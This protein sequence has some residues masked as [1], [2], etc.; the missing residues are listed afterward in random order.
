MRR[1]GVILGLALLGCAGFALAQGNLPPPVK[2]RAYAPNR[3]SQPA[4]RDNPARFSPETASVPD[5]GQWFPPT[6]PAAAPAPSKSQPDPIAK[7]AASAEPVVMNV[8]I[9]EHQDR[10]RFVI[11][12]SDPVKLR[13]LTLTNPNRVVIDMPEV[14][15]RI[16]GP[17]KP[18][19]NSAIHSYRYGLFR[20]GNARFVLDLNMPVTVAEPLI[21][22]P[23]D[24]F[25][26]RVVIDL[27]PIP[28]SKFERTAGWPSDLKEKETAPENVPLGRKSSTRKVVVVD[29]GHGGIDSGTVGID[30][31]MEKDLVLDE[32]KRLGAEL[33]RRG[34]IVHLTRDTDIFIP[35]RQRVAIARSYGADL[36]ISLHA[37][38]NPNPDVTGASVYTLSEK[39]SD[40]EAAALARKENQSDIIA[41]VDLTGQDDSVSHI[42]IDLA[43]R[44]TMNRSSRFAE[45]VVSKL[46]QA[47]DILPRTPH[48]SGA[49]VVL[50]APDVPAVLVELGYLSNKEDCRQMHSASW[51]NGVAKALADAV[52]QNFGPVSAGRD[53]SGGPHAAE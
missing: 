34:Y 49:L 21:L 3:L 48:R 13:V 11:E 20:P 7:L 32:A 4:P 45:M 33:R 23:S 51:R 42:L 29:A 5:Q 30:G 31:M 24:G 36:F 53:F 41:G 12:L 28:Q 35:L 52:D 37:D 40:R 27:F 19:G 6:Q 15:W 8:R 44:D 50:K 14:L 22:P 2:H 46:S 1:L 9:G 16:N 47:T 39:G 43:Q 26:Y 25:G 18:T 10:T 17:Q 38:S